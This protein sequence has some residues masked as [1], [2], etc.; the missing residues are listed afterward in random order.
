[1]ASPYHERVIKVWAA[2]K[3]I[4]QRSQLSYQVGFLP[5]RLLRIP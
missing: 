4:I 3:V 2:E 1:M 5:N